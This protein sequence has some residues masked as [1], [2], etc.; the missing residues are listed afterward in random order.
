[1]LYLTE[2]TI[3][4]MLCNICLLSSFMKKLHCF[5]E[6]NRAMCFTSK[7]VSLQ[8]RTHTETHTQD[9]KPMFFL[10][11]QLFLQR[12]KTLPQQY[13]MYL[14]G[15]YENIYVL[16]MLLYKI[17]FIR[18]VYICVFDDFAFSVHCIEQIS[19]LMMKKAF[20]NFI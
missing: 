2:S 18:S 13:F 14:F 12:N 4:Y 3:L 7:Y 20:N 19:Y 16:F 15:D 17:R 11:K 10:S 9:T 6:V 8:S 1:M 5:L